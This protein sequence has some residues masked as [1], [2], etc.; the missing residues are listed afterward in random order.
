MGSIYGGI[1]SNGKKLPSESV[2]EQGPC[3]DGN[4]EVVVLGPLTFF[5]SLFDVQPKTGGNEGVGTSVVC[6]LY[7][8]TQRSNQTDN[9]LSCFS[10]SGPRHG[11]AR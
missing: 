1:P 5:C 7:I 2:L 4:Q 10:K 9:Q 6:V 11:P 3:I 8:S